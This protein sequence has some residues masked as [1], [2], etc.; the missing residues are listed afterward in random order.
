MVENV[1]KAAALVF[2]FKFPHSSPIDFFQCLPN[3]NRQR[4]LIYFLDVVVRVRCYSIVIFLPKLPV[5][6]VAK[7]HKE[8]SCSEHLFVCRTSNYY[9]HDNDGHVIDP[10]SP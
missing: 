8:Y 10:S 4:I 2:P 5:E 7:N 3:I 6:Q 1:I 9:S